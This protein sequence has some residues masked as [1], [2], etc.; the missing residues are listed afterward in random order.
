MSPVLFGALM[1]WLLGVAMEGLG[2]NVGV[3]V[4]G[5]ARLV[6][7]GFADDMLLFAGSVRA[8]EAA[9]AIV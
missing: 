1:D 8:T 5:C 7:L 6:Q 2:E 4:G 3:R 9:V